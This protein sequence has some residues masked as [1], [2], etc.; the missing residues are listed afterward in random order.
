[1]T[2]RFRRILY[3]TFILIFLVVTPLIWLYASGYRLGGGFELQK[4]GILVL[5]TQPDGA[6][7]LLNGEPHRSLWDKLIDNQQAAARTP[8]K[9]KNILPGT[10]TVRLEKEGFH[11][12]E[13]RLQVTSGATTFAEDV[14]LFKNEL[15]LLEVAG[16][17]QS[18]S[19]SPDKSFLAGVTDKQMVLFDLENRT[20][21]RYTL[22][23]ST[24]DREN[25]AEPVWGPESEK[26]LWN[27]LVFARDDWQ[28][29]LDLSERVGR[30]AK[31]MSFNREDNSEIFYSDRDKLY[32]LDLETLSSQA[33][34]VK[35]PVAGY[36]AR[37]KNVFVLDQVDHSTALRVADKD[38]GKTER[39]IS[40]PQADYEFVHPDRERIVL[41]DVSHNLVY[42]IDP[43]SSI[44]PIRESLSQALQL[45]WGSHDLF[46]ASKF[47]IWRLD[48]ADSSKELLT[49]ISDPVQDLMYH[50][51][52]NYLFYATEHAIH[53]LEL[54]YGQKRESSRLVEFSRVNKAF[55]DKQGR[56]IFFCSEFGNRKGLYRLS[57]R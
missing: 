21:S 38:T 23:T 22:A 9:I 44:K 15:P 13:K 55:L 19:R 57:V 1:M 53:S 3:L 41:R 56:N 25:G 28:N 4:T 48:P 27:Q 5:D 11:S 39:T 17:F 14:I 24:P 16:D 6:R 36:L 31:Q 51:S 7:V 45:E 8:T 26:V 37:G 42:L 46:Y 10:Y 54:K 12:W 33:I 40:L 35:T 2:L 18:I 52:G 20:K 32:S 49:R 47:E 34:A 43:F 50:P 30:Q 29:P